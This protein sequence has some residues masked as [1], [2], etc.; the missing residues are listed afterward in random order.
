[1]DTGTILQ[2]RQQTLANAK[3]VLVKVGSA[4]LTD[5]RGLDLTVVNSLAR[6]LAS[7]H[8]RGLQ[9]A[10]VSSGA[11]AAGR[12][13]LRSYANSPHVTGGESMRGMPARQAASAIGQ[14]RLMHAYDQALDVLGVLTAQVLLTKDD[15]RSQRRFLNA[16]NTFDRLFAWRALP[17]VNENDTVVVDELEF[18][19]ND[20]L[21]ALL[22]NLV[23]A[24]L[25]VN[26]TSA[27]GVFDANPDTA[28]APPACLECI[29]DID[30]LDLS[31]MCGGKT[32]VGSGG[33]HSKLLA[34]RRAAQRGVPTLILRGREPNA[35][36]RA[37][38]G[39]PIGTWVRPTGQHVSRRKFRIAYNREPSGALTVDAGAVTALVQRGKSL[40]PAGVVEVE[41]NFD[42][43]ALVRIQD[44][45]GVTIGVGL[46]NY[47]A[48]DLRRIAGKKNI[49][50][51]TILGFCYHEAVHRDNLL[52]GAAI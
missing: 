6:Q 24:D 37:F 4:V 44:Q 7:L 48:A 16:C 8:G 50:A 41:G 45:A 3:R 38:D 15:F 5:E 36:V 32:S 46:C 13:L 10:L 49:E 21:A 23:E 9:I 51:E 14:S 30:K 52:L 18:G 22:L 27:P 47:K 39:E 28:D 19:D 43:G 1:M 17:I 42:R 33:M 31:A 40:L 12:G 11:V 20:S 35:L 2:E 29:P 26:L 34:A 25:L